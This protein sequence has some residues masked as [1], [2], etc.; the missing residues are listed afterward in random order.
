M[1]FPEVIS[2]QELQLPQGCAVGPSWQL[3]A[4]AKMRAIEVLPTPL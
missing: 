4:L 1:E 2:L 3:R